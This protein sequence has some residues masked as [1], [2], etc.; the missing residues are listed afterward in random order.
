[1]QEILPSIYAKTKEAL[2]NTGVSHQSDERS[3]SDGGTSFVI[4]ILSFISVIKR[5]ESIGWHISGLAF[6]FLY[7]PKIFGS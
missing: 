5:N 3:L 4:N 7:D 6:D 1:M 2:T